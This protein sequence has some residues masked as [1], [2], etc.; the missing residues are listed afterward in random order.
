MADIN[1]NEQA[2]LIWSIA[3]RGLRNNFKKGQFIKFM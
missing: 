1:I 2:N 3:D